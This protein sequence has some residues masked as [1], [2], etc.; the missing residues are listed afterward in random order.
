MNFPWTLVLNAEKYFAVKGEDW[1]VI[2]E[3]KAITFFLKENKEN[4]NS[5]LWYGLGEQLIKLKSR[6]RQM[7][8]A[9]LAA[10]C[11]PE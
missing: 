9:Y 4:Q 1:E 11:L 6:D 8:W 10:P 3:R 5:W 7:N 2:P